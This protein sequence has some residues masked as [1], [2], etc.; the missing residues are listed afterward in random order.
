M[1]RHLLTLVSVT[2]VAGAISLGITLFLIGDLQDQ[3]TDAVS[4]PVDAAEE[5][6]VVMSVISL[7]LLGLGGLLALARRLFAGPPAQGPLGEVLAVTGNPP[8][9]P[10]SWLMGWPLR[11]AGAG[12]W[13]AIAPVGVAIFVTQRADLPLVA[14]GVLILALAGIGTALFVT[15]RLA[16]NEG[17]QNVLVAEAARSAEDPRSPV[18]Y[19]RP[20]RDDPAGSRELPSAGGLVFWVFPARSE[21]DLFA[22]ALAK[23][24]PF[25]AIGEPGQP[26]RQIGAARFD[27]RA[28]TWQE[29]VSALLRRARLVVLRCGD[30]EGFWWEAELALRTLEPRRLV[31]LIPFDRDDYERFCTRA[32]PHVPAPLPPFPESVHERLAGT[33]WGALY[34]RPDWQAKW[35]I[36]TAQPGTMAY[37]FHRRI[38]GELWPMAEQLGFSWGRW[39]LPSSLRHVAIRAAVVIGFLVVVINIIHWGDSFVWGYG[40]AF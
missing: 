26:F 10:R 5:R 17:R 37:H 40:V 27:V 19:L 2:L 18:L 4:G 23:V 38:V 7:G 39:R 30:S 33:A 12:L 11:I 9:K 22:R 20:F 35:A 1:R 31:L 16:Y 25:L 14:K 29:M 32:Q 34:F 24:G 28:E 8:P 21:E 6:V 15:A 13:F 36:F 3:R